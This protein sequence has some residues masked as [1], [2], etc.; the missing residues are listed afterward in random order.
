MRVAYGLPRI[1]SFDQITSDKAVQ[2]SLAS[3]Y[4]SVDNIDLWIGGLAEDHLPNTSM[5]ATFTAILVDQFSRVR[6]GDRFW[7]QNSLSEKM[8]RDIEN[9]SMADIIRRNTE[10]TKLQA[11]VFFFNESTVM[12][13]ETAAQNGQS[14]N[15]N[16]EEN[17]P[18]E[19]CTQP[20]C[21]PPHRPH[22]GKPGHKPNDG[23]H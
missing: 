5:G 2:A 8:V 4:G 14:G 22:H 6:D 3:T 7:Y 17:Q 20:N 18:A 23:N 15:N 9:T 19:V 12:I 21:R 11:D 10:L 16:D 13:D 1:T